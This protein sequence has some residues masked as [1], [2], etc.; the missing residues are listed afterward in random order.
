[1][2]NAECEIKVMMPKLNSEA[3]TFGF[4]LAVCMSDAVMR[5]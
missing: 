1:M 3:E 4:R 5:A 2:Q